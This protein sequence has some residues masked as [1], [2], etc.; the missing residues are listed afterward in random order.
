[1]AGNSGWDAIVFGEV[2]FAIGGVLEWAEQW[3]H[4]VAQL[5][6][7]DAAEDEQLAQV[8]LTP[9]G[10]AVRGW[11]SRDS[12]QEWCPRIEAMFSAAARIGGRGD[13]TFIGVDGPAYRLELA[14]GRASLHRIPA[15]GIEHPIVQ[16]IL[17]A[18]DTKAAKR[19]AL[20][21][22]AEL[23]QLRKVG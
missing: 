8:L 18:V 9:V 1:M 21:L 22:Q 23:D 16:E 13:V 11:F 2:V 20:R 14:N 10:V 4:R 6:K 3:H 17:V 7:F 15:P 12:F 19:A 5:E